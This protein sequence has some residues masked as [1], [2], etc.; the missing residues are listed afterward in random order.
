MRFEPTRFIKFKQNINSLVE[1]IS[2]AH[3]LIDTGS[4][5]PE[6][7]LVKCRRPWKIRKW[8]RSIS[9]G[10]VSKSQEGYS[11]GKMRVK[12]GGGWGILPPMP[13]GAVNCSPQGRN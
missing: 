4:S 3:F 13:L 2:R 8:V 12:V 11:P 5:D 7:V 10:S 6:I 1:F 9:C